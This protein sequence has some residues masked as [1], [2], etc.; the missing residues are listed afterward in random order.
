MKKAEGARENRDAARERMLAW[1][2]DFW[3]RSWMVLQPEGGAD[4]EVWRVGRNYQ[5]FRYQLG[6]NYGGEYPSRFN[7]ASFTY[8]PC[9]Q[10]TETSTL[11]GDFPACIASRLQV[12]GRD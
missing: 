12:L 3:Q 8:D 9:G 7:G 10:K 4:S 5:L 11:T 6:C 2:A 1:C